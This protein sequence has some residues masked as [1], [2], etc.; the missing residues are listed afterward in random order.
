[1]NSST[2]H[3]SKGAEAT[4]IVE[5]NV[6]HPYNGLLFRLEKEGS[7]DAGVTAD[8]P[9]GPDAEGHKAA[10]KDTPCVIPLHEGHAAVKST[11]QKSG[12]QGLGR[13]MAVAV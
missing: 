4:Q 13:E 7:P 8:E 11:E 10:P 1:M 9:G 5:Q 2:T 6:V 12:C 3:N